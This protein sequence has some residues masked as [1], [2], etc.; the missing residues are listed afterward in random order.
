MQEK[1][2][3]LAK[4]DRITV[5]FSQHPQTPSKEQDNITRVTSDHVLPPCRKE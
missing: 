4:P 3:N 1:R 5:R 2:K